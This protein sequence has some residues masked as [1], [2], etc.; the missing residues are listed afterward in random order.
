MS[1]DPLIQAAKYFE[2]RNKAR[3]EF[4]ELEQP[5]VRKIWT[6]IGKV[7]LAIRSEGG[8]EE[9]EISLLRP[10]YRLRSLLLESPFSYDSDE[11]GVAAFVADLQASLRG[12]SPSSS[13]FES[14]R[15]VIKL[16]EAIIGEVN[17][18]KSA[19]KKALRSESVVVIKDSRRAQE[20]SKFL[21]TEFGAGNQ[22]IT[23]KDLESLGPVPHLLYLGSPMRMATIFAGGQ[24]T[25]FLLDPRGSISTFIL[26]PFSKMP[27][28]DGLI[29]GSK[30]VPQLWAGTTFEVSTTDTHGEGL[31]DWDLA[32]TR[33]RKSNDSSE[34][35]ENARF[36][37]LAGHHYIWAESRSGSRCKVLT[38]SSNGALGIED[39]ELADLREN[40]FIIER[41]EGSSASMIDQLADALG[42]SKY[43]KS[44]IAFREMLLEKALKPS[45]L[46]KLETQLKEIAGVQ[47][48]N[49]RRW[50]YSRSIAPQSESDFIKILNFLGKGEV[51]T[52]MWADLDRLRSL[53]RR[54]GVQISQRLL[55][56]LTKTDLLPQLKEEGFAEVSVKDC[57]SIGAFRVEYIGEEVV[58]I[59]VTLIDV[60]RKD[61]N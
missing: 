54:A 38:I 40:Q 44:Q 51:A 33:L 60:I 20:I 39:L 1:V 2:V 25:R 41:T 17:P 50:I 59:P 55:A 35:V 48:T 13:V 11:I 19:L 18:I 5:T 46:A 45:D 47:T 6:A 27:K 10:L 14:T 61:V 12:R 29:A 49:L 52:G 34:L 4:K 36:I 16:L 58:E 32:G 53:H 7:R 57:G 3:F 22:V 15:A 56:A 28:L 31:T 42:G 21:R 8:S 9:D 43:R 23:V 37:G 26:Y 24:D 30:I